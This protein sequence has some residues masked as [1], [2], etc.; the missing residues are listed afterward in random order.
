VPQS[1]EDGSAP[2]PDFYSRRS[3]EL[4]AATTDGLATYSRYTQALV[5]LGLVACFLVYQAVANKSVPLWSASLVIPVAVWVEYQ[6]RRTRLNFMK[7]RSLSEFYERGIARLAHSWEPLDTGEEFLNQD[8]L[9]ARDLD[10]FGL[11]SLYQLIC[12][13]RTQ[14]GSQTLANWMLSSADAREIRSRQVAIAELRARRDLPERLASAAPAH[15]SDFRPDFL[16]QWLHERTGQFPAWSSYLAF[17]LAITAVFLPILYFSG[18]LAL[19]VLWN[20]LAAL[21]VAGFGFALNFR[22]RIKSV[23]DSLGS[24]SIELPVLRALLEIMERESFT[25]SKLTELAGSL[26]GSG[27]SASQILNRLH[28]LIRLA[29][30]RDDELLAYPCFCLLWGTQF[31]MAID[32]WRRNHGLQLLSWLTALGELDALI[33]IS[34]YSYEHPADP[35]PEISDSNPVFDAESLGHPVLR[36]DVCVRNDLRLDDK[37]RFLIVSG[38]NMSGKSTFLRAIGMNIVLALMGAP[39]RCTKLELS[40]V[41]LGASIRIQD[42][43]IDGR[44]HFMAEM[45]RL[46]RMIEAAGENDLMFLADEIMGG[47][48]SHDRRIATEW[49]L[50]AFVQRGAIGA[51]STHDLALTEIAA[52]GLPGRNVYFEDS[53]D[54]GTLAFDYKLREGILTRSNA[55]NIAHILGIDTAAANPIKPDPHR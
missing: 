47:T 13:A 51:I 22:P 52:N 9:Y 48:N 36:E 7:L 45:Q 8:H 4:R 23:L 49:V 19:T 30:V 46:R 41:I 35:F 44:S 17:I 20:A 11:G 18:W 2:A 12:S 5:A 39:V 6:R 31:G 27:L 43:L 24:L 1:L 21:I 40:P 10:L 54:C 29:K 28:T 14:I 26:R 42:S 33:S 38:S 25:S 37:V 3:E 15:V 50:R 16:K 55:L 34:T 53:G 32:R